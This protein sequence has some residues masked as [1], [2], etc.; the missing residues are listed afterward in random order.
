MVCDAA[1]KDNN[2]NNITSSATESNYRTPSQFNLQMPSHSTPQ[3]P[4]QI[5]RQ[6]QS[7]STLQTPS[8]INRQKQSQST[9]QTPSQGIRQKSSQSIIQTS[10]RSHTQRPPNSET[11]TSSEGH[12]ATSNQF[13]IPASTNRIQSS[14]T[15]TP[16]V[17][18]TKLG[19]PFILVPSIPHNTN[20]SVASKQATPHSVGPNAGT[21]S[22]YQTA[23]N[24][25]IDVIQ[26][27]L[28][29]GLRPKKIITGTP[30]NDAADKYFEETGE[31]KIDSL[32]DTDDGSSYKD[33]TDF[34]DGVHFSRRR[35]LT[36]ECIIYFC[37]NKPFLECHN[38]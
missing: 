18:S 4:S 9:L 21:S 15:N 25:N 32:K 22:N 11:R 27:S 36:R 19:S 17:Y 3:T 37:L 13:N 33:S 6:K 30:I 38:L 34:S 7:H 12:L 16:K 31:I 2:L 26:P 35:N 5:N 29:E 23:A 8:Q 10:S 20:Y 24:A 14:K 28:R 1:L